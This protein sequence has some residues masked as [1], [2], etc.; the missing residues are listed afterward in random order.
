MHDRCYQEHGCSASS[1][2][3]Y[4]GSVACDNCNT[5]AAACITAACAG[6]I[7]SSTN[8]RCYD[9]RC[10]QFYDCD[11]ANCEC[12]S[13]CDQVSPPTCGNGS[14]EVMENADNCAGD[15][16][17]G[18]GLNQCCVETDGCPSETPTDCPGA[19]CCCG[20]GEVC[21]FETDLCAP[22]H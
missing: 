13:P 6:V 12:P 5:I 10:Q 2:L 8:D 3:P 17:E 22:S 16:W 4:V 20:Y 15:C 21:S 11:S 9:N 1:W 19:C 14:C 7:D 18:S